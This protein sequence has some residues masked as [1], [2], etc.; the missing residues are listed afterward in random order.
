MTLRAVGVLV[1]CLGVRELYRLG[2]LVQHDWETL[3]KLRVEGV[4]HAGGSCIL[5]A[6]EPMSIGPSP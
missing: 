3:S 4:M 1:G 5:P 2:E 6:P